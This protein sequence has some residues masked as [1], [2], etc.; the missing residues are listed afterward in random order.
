MWLVNGDQSSVTWKRLKECAGILSRFQDQV[1]S[2][3]LF[4]EVTKLQPPGPA[5]TIKDSMK[6]SGSNSPAASALA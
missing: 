1:I 4:E 6:S 5:P 2:P 3:S